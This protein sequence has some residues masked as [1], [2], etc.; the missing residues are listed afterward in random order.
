MYPILL[1][2]DNIVLSSFDSNLIK[3]LQ[4]NYPKNKN[5]II[6]PS[7]SQKNINDI[8]EINNNNISYKLKIVGIYDSK[9]QTFIMNYYWQNIVYTTSNFLNDISNESNI[10][11]IIIQIN[12]YQNVESTIK[13]LENYN[14]TLMNNDNAE[15]LNRYYNY[16]N[17]IKNISNII[18]I[19]SFLVVII[20]EFIIFHDNKLNIAIMKSI[21]YSSKKLALLTTFYSQ[22]LTIISLT[23]SCIIITIIYILL[24]NLIILNINILIQIVIVFAIIKIITNFILFLIINKIN[25][26][27]FIKDE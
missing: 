23:I 18:L 20:V 13:Q 12:D 19:L 15:V 9:N 4:G 16:Y 17:S 21:G 27:K 6:V 25:I 5:E 2:N 3:I 10:N 7:N 26:I 11:G 8:I 14:I 1:L 24:K 22:I